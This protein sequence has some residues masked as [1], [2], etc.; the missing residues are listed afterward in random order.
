MSTTYPG[1]IA[2]LRERRATA[3]L[4]GPE[5]SRQKHTDRGKMLARGQLLWP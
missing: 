1:L 5:R 2:E 3:A 4:G